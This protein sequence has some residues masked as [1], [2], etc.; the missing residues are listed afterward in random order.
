MGFTST[1]LPYNDTHHHFHNNSLQ[2][3]HKLSNWQRA[4]KDS[5][6]TFI[7]LCSLFGHTLQSLPLA[8]DSIQTMTSTMSQGTRPPGMHPNHPHPDPTKP[9]PNRK[10]T[11][12]KHEKRD[13]LPKNYHRLAGTCQK[14]IYQCPVITC[15]AKPFTRK[16]GLM[17]HMESVSLLSSTLYWLI[18]TRTG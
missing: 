12:D 15:E 1:C 10:T 8:I 9:K 5:A 13:L 17:K 4:I 7:S 18:L 2:H 16:F 6:V 14:G 11:Y 3:H